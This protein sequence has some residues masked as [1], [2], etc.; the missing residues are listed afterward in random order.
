M[1]K[2]ILGYYNLIINFNIFHKKPYFLK[3][4]EKSKNQILK[5]IK[6]TN[7]TRD[8]KLFNAFCG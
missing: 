7:Y 6:L 1:F 8:S 2:N 4:V 3:E 5:I